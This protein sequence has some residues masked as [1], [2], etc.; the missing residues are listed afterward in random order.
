MY[1]YV[2]RHPFFVLMC[3]K[4]SDKTVQSIY[5]NPIFVIETELKTAANHTALQ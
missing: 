2:K 3:Y 1:A 5:K 4:M